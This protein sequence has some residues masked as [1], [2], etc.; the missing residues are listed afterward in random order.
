M[1]KATNIIKIFENSKTSVLKGINL[2]IEDGDFISLMGRSGSGKSTF[3]YL[4]S[5]LDRSFEG[6]VEYDGR[7]VK[8]MKEE[9]IHRIRNVE[10][11][12]VFQFHY[13]IS[14][15]SALEN[16]LLPARKSKEVALRTP[17][18][19]DLLEQVGLK[20]K[21]DWPIGNLSGGEQQ[22]VAIARALLMKP[23]YVF[24]DE[25]TGNLDSVTGEAVLDLFQKFN[26]EYKT[27]IIYV[28]HDQVFGS[29]AKTKI[30]MLDGLIIK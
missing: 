28:T 25:P 24:A 11:G 4:L 20:D 14:E 7:D 22:R 2:N 26:N 12:F 16:I 1:I 15:L 8:K 5:T 9:E 23:K 27:S 29:K 10:I 19:K 17:F 21:G 13:L 18:A 3:L 30:Q 6:T